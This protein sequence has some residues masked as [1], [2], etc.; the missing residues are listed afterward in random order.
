MAQA[1]IEQVEETV[2]QLD[3]YTVTSTSLVRRVPLHE[4]EAKAPPNMAVTARPRSRIPYYFGWCANVVLW[5]ST[6]WLIVHLITDDIAD[7]RY[8]AAPI[9]MVVAAAVLGGFLADQKPQVCTCPNHHWRDDGC[10]VDPTLVPPSLR[11]QGYTEFS[12]D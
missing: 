9:I 3:A 7:D 1:W 10:L 6:A 12:G 8:V 2:E 4:V 11:H 5:V